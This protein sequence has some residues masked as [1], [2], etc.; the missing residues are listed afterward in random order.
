[1]LTAH[2]ASSAALAAVPL[3][4]GLSLYGSARY[5]VAIWRGE[6]SP[7]SVTWFLWALAPLIAS[8]VG[9]AHGVGLAEVTTLSAA[10]GA[11]LVCVSTVATSPRSS[12][13]RLSAGD[14]ACGALSLAA[15]L[16]WWRTSDPRTAIALSLAADLLAGLPT[17][18]KAYRDPRSESVDAYATMTVGAALTFVTLRHWSF[19]GAGFPLYLLLLNLTLTYL[20]RGGRAAPT[21]VRVH[22]H[23]ATTEPEVQA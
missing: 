23:D 8:L 22:L 20:T 14:L 2:W 13:G 21:N 12:I 4:A 1:M 16:A 9:L 7:N 11:L 6:A 19:V 15:L 18:A 17:L 10:L 3:A 5:C